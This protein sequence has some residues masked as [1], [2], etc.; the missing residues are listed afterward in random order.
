[1]RTKRIILAVAVILALSGIA[2]FAQEPLASQKGQ[3]KTD[4]KIANQI[5]TGGLPQDPSST[6]LP[7]Q[8]NVSEWHWWSAW[9][10]I[11]V[12]I[13]RQS[14]PLSD[15]GGATVFFRGSSAANS[16]SKP[17]GGRNGIDV[18]AIAQQSDN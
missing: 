14:E 1:M 9:S 12:R 18:G 7:D 16:Q 10:A 13:H 11:P 4:S 5:V 8:R 2:A 6:I 17:G 15:C 3:I